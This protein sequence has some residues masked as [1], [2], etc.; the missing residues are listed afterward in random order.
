MAELKTK[1]ESTS[2]DEFLGAIAD[3]K[4]RADALRLR[5]LMAKVT[6]DKGS[7]WGSAIVG[8]GKRTYRNASGKENDWFET[9]FSPRKGKTALY[10]SSGAPLD[11]AAVKK[12]GKVEVAKGCF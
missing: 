4:Q 10:V 9:G 6:G 7:M 3:D 5:A 1:K 11:V 2:V 12:L 8:F